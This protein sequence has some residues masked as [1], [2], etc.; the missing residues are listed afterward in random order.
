MR[1]LLAGF[2]TL[3]ISKNTRSIVVLARFIFF[4]VIHVIVRFS[5]HI[6]TMFT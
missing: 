4:G 1:T 6:V 5:S 3:V 2:A